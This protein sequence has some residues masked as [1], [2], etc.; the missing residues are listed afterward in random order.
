M[1]RDGRVLADFCPSRCGPF[2][3]VGRHLPTE[4]PQ[5]T[6]RSPG[7]SKPPSGNVATGR[8]FEVTDE[9]G[10]SPSG[11]YQPSILNEPFAADSAHRRLGLDGGRRPSSEPGRA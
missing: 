5:L 2:A 9:Q 8:A 11:T 6:K 3:Q 10:S 1:I 7:F 4:D